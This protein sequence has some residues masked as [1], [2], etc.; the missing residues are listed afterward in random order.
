VHREA[1]M[2]SLARGFRAGNIRPDTG[3]VVELSD[4]EFHRKVHLD[5]PAHLDKH[6]SR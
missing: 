3:D 4:E 1:A 5:A 6:A 2:T